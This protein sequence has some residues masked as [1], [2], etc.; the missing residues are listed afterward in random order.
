MIFLLVVQVM[1]TLFYRLRAM[2]STTGPSLML[3]NIAMVSKWLIPCKD[4]L[5]IARISSPV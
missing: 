1:L 3:L 5:F 4:S 2:F